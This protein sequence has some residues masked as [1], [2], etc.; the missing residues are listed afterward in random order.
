LALYYLALI[1]VEE[2]EEK[3]SDVSA[4]DIGIRHDYH[5]V[6]PEKNITKRNNK[7]KKKK[8]KNGVVITVLLV[9]F[10]N[11]KRS[12]R[13]VQCWVCVCKKCYPLDHNANDHKITG[14]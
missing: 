14:K 4:V 13:F 5:S 9:R 8:K 12:I 6:I 3:D 7:N 11:P 1:A 10:K 2:G